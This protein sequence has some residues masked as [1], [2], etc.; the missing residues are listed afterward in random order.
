MPNVIVQGDLVIIFD[1]EHTSTLQRQQ[2]HLVHLDRI[3]VEWEASLADCHRKWSFQSDSKAE[4][5][6]PCCDTPLRISGQTV[7]VVLEFY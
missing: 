6:S 2:N 7:M 3:E 1:V 5:H 4:A